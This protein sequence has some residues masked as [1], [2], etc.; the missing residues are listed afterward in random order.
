MKGVIHILWTRG[1]GVP[2]RAIRSGISWLKKKTC[3]AE[4]KAPEPR[5]EPH[6]AWY[7]WGEALRQSGHLQ[8]ALAHFDQA[9]KL[10]PDDFKTWHARGQALAELGHYFDAV[11]SYMTA[12]RLNPTDVDVR[13]DRDV[14]LAQLRHQRRS[15]PGR[16][17]LVPELRLRATRARPAFERNSRPSREAA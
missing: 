12:L 11:A 2:A 4:H 9:I 6:W 8:Q 10:K 16:S 14:A 1:V 5:L 3:R 15:T 13:R 17:H 7:Q